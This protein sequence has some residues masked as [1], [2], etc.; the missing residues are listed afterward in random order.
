MISERYFTHGDV[1]MT[2]EGIQLVG[3]QIK[4]LNPPYNIGFHRIFLSSGRI[5]LYFMATYDRV[6]LFSEEIIQN[7]EVNNV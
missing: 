4:R 6:I 7:N 2:C 1:S 5:A 3:L